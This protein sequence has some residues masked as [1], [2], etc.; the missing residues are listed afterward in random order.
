MKRR[1]GEPSRGGL[2]FF[3]FFF[4]FFFFLHLHHFSYYAMPTKPLSH[5]KIPNIWTDT[6]RQQ[7]IRLRNTTP[8]VSHLRLLTISSSRCPHHNGLHFFW[9]KPR[10]DLLASRTFR[11][12]KTWLPTGFSALRAIA[13]RTFAAAR[14]SLVARNSTYIQPTVSL[15]AWCVSDTVTRPPPAGSSNT[16]ATRPGLGPR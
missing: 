6:R 3:F 1:P 11:A 8:S 9:P 5:L 7:A 10:L 14:L 12:L 4:F 15:F 13:P 16:S 2:S